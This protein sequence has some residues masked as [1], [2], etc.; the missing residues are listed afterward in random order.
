LSGGLFSGPP[1]YKF[2]TFPSTYITVDQTDTCVSRDGLRVDIEV[3]FQYQLAASNLYSAVTRYRDFDKWRVVVESSAVSAIQHSCSNFTISS[4]QSQRGVIQES[5]QANLKQKLEGDGTMLANGEVNRGVYA[6]A[7][8]LQLRNIE[9]PREYQEAVA[10]K[11]SAE[12]DIQLAL[13]QRKQ[14]VTK[15][16]T[17]L[18]ASKEQARQILATALNEADVL[19]TEAKL[20]AEALTFSFSREAETLVE[21]KK[22]LN[23]DTNGVLGYLS[24]KMLERAVQVRVAA[25][26]P[27]RLSRKDEL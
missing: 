10:E 9:L 15:A 27:A 8:S 24:N 23:L 19:L 3:T 5:M 14:E 25:G 26:E 6:L 21:V 11:Q 12:E 20:K 7:V 22:S 17:D 2:I 4:F 16:Q 13:N 1:G 18:L